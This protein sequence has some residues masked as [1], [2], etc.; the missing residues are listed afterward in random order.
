MS[1]LDG[2]L[3]VEVESHAETIH[4]WNRGF[5]QSRGTICAEESVWLG[6]RFEMNNRFVLF[7][8]HAH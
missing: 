7:L 1:G 4:G 8:C 2:L 6:P 3:R 5:T